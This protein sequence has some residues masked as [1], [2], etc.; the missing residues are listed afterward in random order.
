MCMHAAMHSIIYI[1]LY[2]YLLIAMQSFI[3]LQLNIL[4]QA[5]LELFLQSNTV[6][7]VGSSLAPLTSLLTPFTGPTDP[8]VHLGGLTGSAKI[9][10]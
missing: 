2:S 7:I 6:T 5:V 10:L 8:V 9:C 4:T 3:Q 1:Y